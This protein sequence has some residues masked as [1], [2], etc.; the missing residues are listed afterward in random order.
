MQAA[1]RHEALPYDGLDGLVSSCAAL[2]EAGQASDYRVMFLVAAAKLDALRDRIGNES[3]DIAFV[4]TDQHGRNPARITTMLDSFQATANGR[5][6]VGVNEVVHAGLASDAMAEARLAESVLN[7][8]QL[9]SWPLSV[10]CLYDA[11][12]L[13]G[14]A[15]DEMR[16]SHPVVRGEADNGVYDA[17]HAATLFQEPLA[18]APVDA[19]WRRF[20][21]G[22][23]ATARAFVRD[24]VTDRGLPDDRLDDL[25]LAAN[26]VVTN[27]LR[28]GGGTCRLTVWE[29]DESVVCEVRDGGVIDDPLVGRLAP[30]P[31]AVAGRGL[32][33]ANHLCDLVQVRSSR[34]GTVARLHIDWVT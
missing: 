28:H 4:A 7:S 20:G 29:D 14:A 6:C 17:G 15:L 27:S 5:H 11:D 23:L 26:E 25:V 13:D 16:R 2:A 34:T 3:D 32:W 21:F 12:A 9:T 31:T 8:A 33:L 19:E 18:D 1:Y 22:E 30:L 24:S 10:V